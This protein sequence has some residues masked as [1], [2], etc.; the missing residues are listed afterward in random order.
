MAPSLLSVKEFIVTYEER[1]TG[2]W[3][4]EKEKFSFGLSIKHSIVGALSPVYEKSQN[5]QK[6]QHVQPKKPCGPKDPPF[7]IDQ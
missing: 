6:R 3:I 2:Q 4:L 5:Q 1:P 7:K